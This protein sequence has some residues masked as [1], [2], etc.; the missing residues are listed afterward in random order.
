MKIGWKLNL[1]FTLIT[2]VLL[3][4]TIISVI[5]LGKIENKTQEALDERVTSINLAT[6]TRFQLTNQGLKLRQ[7]AL[8]GNEEDKQAL[9][10]VAS[11]LDENVKKLLNTKKEDTV[12]WIDSINEYNECCQREWTKT[13][14]QTKA[15]KPRRP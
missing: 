4:S 2:V 13:T 12:R 3:V 1:S 9:L 6:S 11:T 5:N 10:S 8:T 7:Y 15:V 14:L